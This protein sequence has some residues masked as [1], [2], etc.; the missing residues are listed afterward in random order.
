MQWRDANPNVE[1]LDLRFRDVTTDGVNTVRRVYD[2]LGLPFTSAAEQGI[3]KWEHDNPKDRHG[4]AEYSSAA[5]GTTDEG[6]LQAFSAY[7]E[8]FASYF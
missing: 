6:I 7:R 2:F 5:M 8:R 3:L 1:I 4:K